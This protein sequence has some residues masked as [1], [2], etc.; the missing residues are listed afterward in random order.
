MAENKPH[1][2]HETHLLTT[3]VVTILI[4]SFHGLRQERVAYNLGKTDEKKTPAF[5][6]WLC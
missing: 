5:L 6:V 2:H 3:K 4:S 1:A